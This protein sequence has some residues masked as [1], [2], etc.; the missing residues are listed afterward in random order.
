MIEILLED[1]WSKSDAFLMPLTG[2]HRE[3]FYE[4]KSYLFWNEYSIEDYY[5]IMCIS[6]EDDSYDEM[7]RY[8]KQN[9]FPKLDNIV[10]N[11]DIQGRSIYI[12]D[13]SEWAMDIQMFLEAKYSKMSREAKKLIENY[14]RF[15][16]TKI[17][18]EIYSCM[19]PNKNMSLLGN[20]TP[21]EYCSKHY[22]LDL[23][24]MKQVGEV[25]A[26]YDRMSET[27]LTDIDQICQSD[28]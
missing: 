26:K 8:C 5:L 18:V 14:H 7:L 22:G 6:Y 20:L 17:P 11:Y 1:Y 13:M 16:K 19:Y 24:T 10:E 23:E 25:G 12:L 2:L 4:V 15:D 28:T 27:L 9:I 3:E 21:I